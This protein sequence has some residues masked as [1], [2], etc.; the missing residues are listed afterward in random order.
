ML[1]SIRTTFTLGVL[2]LLSCGKSSMGDPIINI[3][4][5]LAFEGK[6]FTD[7]G[8]YPKL[9]TC[10]SLG[11]SPGLQWSKAPAGTQSYAVTMHHF[12]PTY[13]TEPKHVYYVVYNI[14]STASSLQENNTT[15]GSFGINTVDRK[16]K[17]SPPCSQGPGA[18][19]Y[20]LTLYALNGQPA[21]A[22]PAAQVTMDVLLNGIRGK[23]LD[24]AV[25]TVTYTRF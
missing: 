9:Y 13:P 12:P 4:R 7:Q 17:Y 15:V 6:G 18:K 24:S 14:P 19:T 1:I 8:T 11:I 23:I 16:N 25:L 20:Y 21:I 3:P 10:D 2:C 5:Q 22:V